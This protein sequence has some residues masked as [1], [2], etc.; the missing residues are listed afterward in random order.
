MPKARW[1]NA[2][3]ADSNETIIVEGNHYFPPDSV[4]QRR[5]RPSDTTSVC[6]WKGTASYVDVVVG[7]EVNPSAGWFY[8][9][10]K[11]AAQEIAGHLA[12]G[13]GVTIES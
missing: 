4:D 9:Q 3:I 11:P 12:F 10:P 7:D 6:A 5:I 2:V 1:N 8:P 13:Q